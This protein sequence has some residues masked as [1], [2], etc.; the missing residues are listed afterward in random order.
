[1][2][3][4]LNPPPTSVESAA[5]AT[6]PLDRT[7]PPIRTAR[8]VAAALGV[9]ADRLIVTPAPG[10][11]TEADCARCE[12]PTELINGTLVEK[13]VNYFSSKVAMQIVGL[14]F[15]YLREN[16]I[17]E[18]SGPDGS[19]RMNGGNLRLPDI[20]VTRLD[21]VPSDRRE[22]TLSVGPDLAIEV[23]SPGNTAQ[24]MSAK[25]AE[26][27]ASGVTEVWELD[28]LKKTGRV[29][30]E[31]E[32]VRVLSAEDSFEGGDILPGLTVSISEVLNAAE[33]GA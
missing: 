7:T 15:V 3:A 28:P 18:V 26:Y 5:S 24:E 10:S 12:R 9:S 19:V 6:A 13:S 31:N 20:A 22:R 17:A 4:V 27:F 21:R 33:R 8:E 23:L 16:P 2:T 32:C 25:R 11:A 1:M 14:L 29:F 30:R